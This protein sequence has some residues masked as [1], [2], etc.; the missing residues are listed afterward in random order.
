MQ[1]AVNEAIERRCSHFKV[2]AVVVLRV[3]VTA[4]SC[5]HE[6]LKRMSM[7]GFCFY[8]FIAQPFSS[9]VVDQEQS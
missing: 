7:R 1:A 9:N 3:S 5:G 4:M 8:F 2:V 6:E